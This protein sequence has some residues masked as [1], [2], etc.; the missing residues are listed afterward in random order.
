MSLRQTIGQHFV[1][2]M[3]GKSP[4]YG[5]K[6]AITTVAATA[7][8]LGEDN[9]GGGGTN[10]AANLQDERD[11]Y[12]ITHRSGPSLLVL[13]TPSG[14][15]LTLDTTNYQYVVPPKATVR[16]PAPDDHRVQVL[17]ENADTVTFVARSFKG[18]ADQI[19]LVPGRP[20]PYTEVGTN[21][22]ILNVNL[23]AGATDSTAVIDLRGYSDGIVAMHVTIQAAPS[24]PNGVEIQPLRWVGTRVESTSIA[25][26]YQSGNLAAGDHTFVLPLPGGRKYT[27]AV[28][29]LDAA[30]TMQTKGV[31][32]KIR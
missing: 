28:K 32:D 5:N 14:E 2:L 10:D 8:K 3:A 1:L 22:A 16:I 9:T 25:P 4:A 26:K 20:G 29:N 19:P 27:L 24:T 17:S 11:G 6:S 7:W 15:N 31:L 18:N 21:D 23:G 30:K 12:V 13:V